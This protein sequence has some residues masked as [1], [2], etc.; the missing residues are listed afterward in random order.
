MKKPA[1]I[2]SALEDLYSR[3]HDDE[4][5]GQALFEEFWTE[6]F[7]KYKTIDEYSAKLRTLVS[8]PI[9]QHLRNAV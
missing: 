7:Q 1:K 6:Q 2:W 8:R 4:K 9:S 5:A 3:V